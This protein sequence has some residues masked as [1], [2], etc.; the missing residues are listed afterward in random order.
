[1]MKRVMEEYTKDFFFYILGKYSMLPLN[2]VV[3]CLD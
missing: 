2:H 3:I 1:M